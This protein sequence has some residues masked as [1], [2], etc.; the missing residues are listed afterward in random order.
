MRTCRKT[1]CMV[2]ATGSQ[3]SHSRAMASSTKAQS[4]SNL[5][6]I[7]LASALLPW[8]AEWTS[9]YSGGAIRRPLDW[10]VRSKLASSK[11]P[12]ELL[13]AKSRDPSAAQ[14]QPTPSTARPDDL[15]AK[16]RREPRRRKLAGDEGEPAIMR[17][18]RQIEQR[19]GR[20][21]SNHPLRADLIESSRHGG[22]AASVKRRQ[23]AI[24]IP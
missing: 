15:R 9:R 23:A 22:E 6:D 11:R 18:R 10:V 19:V 1:C 13:T 3:W 4:I 14:D 21:T 17:P 2:S 12:T 20:R 7:A 24:I 5:F 8:L 16:R